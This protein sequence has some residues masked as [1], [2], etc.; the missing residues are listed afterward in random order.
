MPVPGAIVPLPNPGDTGTSGAVGTMSGVL[1][2]N[3]GVGTGTGGGTCAAAPTTD[4][5][6][7]VRVNNASALRNIAKSSLGNIYAT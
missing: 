6:G 7:I 5:S 1:G 4:N 3:C 2:L